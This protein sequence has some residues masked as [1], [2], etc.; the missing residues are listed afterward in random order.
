MALSDVTT[1]RLQL[2]RWDVALHTPALTRLNACPV[3]VRYLNDGVP[4]TAPES[5]AQSRRFAAHWEQHGFGLW[6]V[7]VRATGEVIGFTGLSHP[8]WFPRVAH[9]V[10]V[11]WRLHPSAWGNGYATEA[12]RAAVAAART[13]LGLSRLI[14]VID[15]ENVASIAVAKRLGFGR[16]SVGAHPQR[17]GTIE[18]YALHLAATP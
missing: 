7:R 10:E 16:E 11:G 1:E 5:A 12:G 3:A 2:S 14:A 13:S 18:L 17:P 4:Y 6:A 15:P 9:E 8:L